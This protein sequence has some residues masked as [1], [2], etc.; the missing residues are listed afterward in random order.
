MAKSTTAP[1]TFY[2]QPKPKY[3]FKIGKEFY[4]RLQPVPWVY[5]KPD[6][7]IFKKCNDEK[8]IAWWFGK[9]DYL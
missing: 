9:R 3:F 7:S 8:F 6:Y 2:Q 5:E 1:T 4:R